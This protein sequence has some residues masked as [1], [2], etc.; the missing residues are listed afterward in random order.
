MF[1]HNYFILFVKSNNMNYSGISFSAFEQV[2][3]P[4]YTA[5]YKCFHYY[6]IEMAPVCLPRGRLWWRDLRKGFLV[7]LRPLQ[8]PPGRAFLTAYLTL[9]W[10]H[11]A[12]R[13]VGCTRVG[14]PVASNQILI[15]HSDNRSRSVHLPTA[16]RG[17][18][19]IWRN[20]NHN[21]HQQPMATIYFFLHKINAVKF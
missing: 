14:G 3:L 5:L 12:S 15:L 19:W 4:G 13:E 20:W 9:A 17:F 8:S 11:Q 16:A 10:Q 21:N 1:A 7:S 2:L 18:S 6:Y